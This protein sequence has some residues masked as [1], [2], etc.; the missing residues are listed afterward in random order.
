[1]AIRQEM[2]QLLKTTPDDQLEVIQLT[3][4]EYEKSLHEEDELALNGSMYDIAWVEVKGETYFVYALH[5]DAEDNLLG[6]LDE[7]VKR[8]SS[9]KKPVPS[10]LLQFFSLDFISPQAKF[11]FARELA[12]KIS[13]LYPMR[14]SSFYLSID[15]PPPKS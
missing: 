5:D 11:Y 14:Y 3:K 2:K 9:D 13:P 4:S 7:V 10:Q 15:S 8:S 12:Q 1:M 6:F